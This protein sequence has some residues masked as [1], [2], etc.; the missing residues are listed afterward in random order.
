MLMTIRKSMIRG[1]VT[2]GGAMQL[3]VCLVAVSSLVIAGR[4]IAQQGYS[5]DDPATDEVSALEEIIVTATRRDEG[6]QEV[7]I[8][9]SAFQGSYIKSM[10]IT[11]SRSLESLTPGLQVQGGFSN[12]SPQWNI[13]GIGSN[14]FDISDV[15]GVGVYVD[16]I[17]LNSNVGQGFS[18]Y[19]TERVEVLRG[20]QG[21]LFGA[22]T[23]GGA[24]QFVS[25]LPSGEFGAD[26]S[27]TVGTFGQ[28]KIEGAF[29]FPITDKLAVRTA[30]FSDENDGVAYNAFLREDAAK[31]DTTAWRITAKYEATED[32]EIV[33]RVWHSSDTGN[34]LVTFNQGT[35][36]PGTAGSPGNFV[37]GT[38]CSQAAQ[39][40][41][42]CVDGFGY[43]QQATY[44]DY[45]TYEGDQRDTSDITSDA[46]VLKIIWDV[47]DM[48]VTSISAFK[49]GSRFL[50]TNI[51]G[52]REAFFT[53]EYD[54]T[55]DQYTQE[56]RFASAGYGRLD[57]VGGL[58]YLF[59]EGYDSY[60]FT[61]PPDGV[62]REYDL[63]RTNLSVFAEGDYDITDELSLTGGVRYS[64][65]EIEAIDY[66]SNAFTYTG[67][68]VP[69][70]ATSESFMRANQTS[71]SISDFTQGSDSDAVTGRVI[72]R[73][74]LS[75]DVSTYGSFSRGYRAGSFNGVAF[76]ASALTFVDPEYVDAFEVGVKSEF[77]DGRARLNF[78]AFHNDYT[79]LQVTTLV[80]LNFQLANAGSAVSQGL[81]MELELQPTD[82][83]FGRFGLSVLDAEY[84]EFIST[85]GDLSGAELENAP[86]LT[87]NGLIRYDIP[88]S[89]G[90]LVTLQ[91][92]FSYKGEH[93]QDFSNHKASI[94]DGYWLVNASI[95]FG[96]EDGRF[97]INAWVKNLTDEEYRVNWFNV[98]TSGF[99]GLNL[100]D[101]LT[102]GVTFSLRID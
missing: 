30:Y 4:A 5:S 13:R 79:D 42:Q 94:Q 64:T 57:W 12:S 39:A 84:E 51:D 93:F 62:W 72:L 19:D 82:Q 23:T 21:T 70:V 69:N 24:I 87:F 63:E 74:Q 37:A 96:P 68:F 3:A 6:I 34:E 89:E 14:G 27:L 100:G 29:E 11:N 61:F 20:P 101:P 98:E 54:S 85:V 7:P 59:E 83:L 17:Y 35:F 10:G 28:R 33:F 55:V 48:T 80:S 102:S 76:S 71:V 73:Y 50:L 49:T 31:T 52:S 44:S 2:G 41:F 16:D 67:G 90:Y 66:F 92:D 56:L 65:D 40:A 8:S 1:A 25:R 38:L 91:T 43:S 95:N 81:D 53:E 78:S 86:D 9:I 58:F 45:H 47:A 99:N 75:E 22:N 97:G 60:V 36:V 15:G 88:V 18:F 46:G 26:A 77:W 32:L